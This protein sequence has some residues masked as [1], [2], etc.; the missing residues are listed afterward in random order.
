[1][2]E[3]LIAY[4]DQVAPKRDKYKKRN[5]LYYRTIYK[6]Y[7]FAIP[8]NSRVVEIGCGTGDL[9][10]R[11][12]P[13]VGLGIDFSPEMIRIARQKYPSLKFLVDDAET[14]KVKETFDYVIVSD[15]LSNLHDVQAALKNIRNLCHNGTRVVFSSF[16]YIW[17][18]FLKFGELLRIRQR[19]PLQNWL[20]VKDIE[21]LLYLEG[22]EMIKLERKLLIPKYIPVLGFIFNRIFANLPGIRTLDLINFIMARPLAQDGSEYSVSIV[23]P[24]RNEKGNIENAILRTPGF[25][26]HQQFIFMEGNSG[27]NTYEEMLRVQ[28]K[29]RDRDI[30]VFRQS[31]K[32]KGNAVREGFERATG[33]VLMILDADLTT[34]PEDMPKFYDAIARGKG[35]F[36]NGCRLVYP[37]EKQAM[38]FLNYLGNKFFGWFFTYLLCI[39]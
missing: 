14:M 12:K 19:Q 27:D 32:G 20:S 37:M 34:P 5:R 21:N 18:P 11:V 13:S 39:N 22:L 15:L 1:M 31:G 38:R 23:I 26:T 10:Y 25:G 2:K 3:E 4:Y 6:F 29:Y 35:E 28:K 33:D 7:R 16:N 8:E 9:L 30:L 24:A 36:I 17:E